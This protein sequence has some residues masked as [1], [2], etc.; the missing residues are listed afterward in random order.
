METVTN[1]GKNG[2]P[3]IL[4]MVC[5]AVVL[6]LFFIVLKIMGAPKQAE[7]NILIQQFH[8]PKDIKL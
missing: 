3:S 7:A 5:A 6:L 8:L 2:R 1:W 4:Q